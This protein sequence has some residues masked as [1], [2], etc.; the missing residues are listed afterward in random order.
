MP[1]CA[2]TRSGAHPPRPPAL[3]C[4]PTAGFGVALLLLAGQEDSLGSRP[5]PGHGL[6]PPRARSPGLSAAPGATGALRPRVLLSDSAMLP[7][8]TGD[9]TP[10]PGWGLT[11]GGSVATPTPRPSRDL[12]PSEEVGVSLQPEHD[13]GA[14]AWVALAR[15]LFLQATLGLQAARPPTASTSARAPLNAVTK[16]RRCGRMSQSHQFVSLKARPGGP[17]VP[18]PSPSS[19][20]IAPEGVRPVRAHTP[21]T[22]VQRA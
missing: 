18:S 8:A 14:P 17:A 10:F 2:P 6:R 16:A 9:C 20:V 13:P 3:K 11:A 1:R 15:V 21:P 12:R 5:Q 7:E 22:A 19:P 4:F